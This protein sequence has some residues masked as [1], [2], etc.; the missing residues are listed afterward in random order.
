MWNQEETDR[1]ALQRIVALLFSLACLANCAAYAPEPVRR[2]VMWIL[3]P[4]EACARNAVMGVEIDRRAYGLALS[5]MENDSPDDALCLAQTFC[6]LAV[7]HYYLFVRLCPK[8]GNLRVAP[9]LRAKVPYS[10]ADLAVLPSA[11]GGGSV[12]S[13]PGPWGS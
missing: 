10:L 2:F 11:G 7:L 13:A 1:Q 9:A 3:R 12:T 5:P 4:A 6:V 8:R